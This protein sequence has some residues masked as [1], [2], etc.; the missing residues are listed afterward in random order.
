M[1]V[2]VKSSLYLPVPDPVNVNHNLPVRESANLSQN[3]PVND[4]ANGNL[5]ISLKQL[6]VPF[7]FHLPFYRIMECLPYLERSYSDI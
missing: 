7:M 3:L 6:Y 1:N 5:R 4:Q 2:P